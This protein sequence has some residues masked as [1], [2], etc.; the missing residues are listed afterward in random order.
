MVRAGAKRAARLSRVTL[1]GERRRVDLVLPSDEPIGRLLPEVLVLL[2]DAV[3]S[4]P[5]PRHLV[6]GNGTVLPQDGSLASAGVADG[7][8]LRLV[9]AQYAP[10]APVVHDVT[11]EVA[12]DLDLRAWRWGPAS[13]RWTSGAMALVLS[14]TAAL[15]AWSAVG[16]S[17]VAGWLLAIA[18]AALAGGAVTA[19][20]GNRG[21]GTALMVTGGALGACGTWALSDAHRWAVMAHWGGLVG[22]LVLTLAVLGLFSPVGRGGLVGAGALAFTG[23]GWEAVAALT[24]AAH[25]AVDQSRLGGVLAVASVVALGVLPRCALVA[26]GL[27]RLDDRRAGGASV[28]RYEVGTA[29]AAAH[30]GLSVATVTVAAS[31]AAAGWLLLAAPNAWTVVMSVLLAVALVSRA[32]AFPLIAEVVALQAAAVVLLA[33]LVAVWL[34]RSATAGPWPVL[35]LCAAA[36]LPLVVLAVDPPEHV[37]VRLRRAMDLGETLGV[38]A[39]FPLL[40]GVFGVYGQ[41]LGAFK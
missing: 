29:L 1:V 27:T 39:L 37:R 32:R 16:A 4:P 22:V 3:S 11:D 13:R 6:T 25:G 41:L 38:V 31:A 30:Q 40:L 35:V 19:R 7:A 18:V 24:H 26:A 23:A 9:R 34:D 21:L 36:L 33:R 28:S 2:D 17:T 20:M 12:D 8:V 15:L 14:L 5:V 10:A